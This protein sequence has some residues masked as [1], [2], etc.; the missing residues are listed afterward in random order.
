MSIVSYLVSEESFIRV[1]KIF[2][3]N[4][5]SFEILTGPWMSWSY[6]PQL[7]FF[8]SLFVFSLFYVCDS[9]ELF[10]T[11]LF[12]HN[13][14]LAFWIVYTKYKY[15]HL[16]FPDETLSV[17]TPPVLGHLPYRR[18]VPERMFVTL[19]ESTVLRPCPDLICWSVIQRRRLYAI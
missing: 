13:P 16:L 7:F 17:N 4:H 3:R 1:F 14:F 2:N 19:S 9:L 12:H 10:R 11:V 15:L 6:L 5:P 18:F 8:F